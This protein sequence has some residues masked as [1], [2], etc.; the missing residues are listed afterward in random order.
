MFGQHPAD[1]GG[2]AQGDNAVSGFVLA[3]I[4]RH[5]S[6]GVVPERDAAEAPIAIELDIEV[7]YEGAKL[8]L[9]ALPGTYQIRLR[10]SAAKQQGNR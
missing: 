4:F 7:L 1:V 8:A 10:P 5:R 2:I 3:L 6:L 9:A